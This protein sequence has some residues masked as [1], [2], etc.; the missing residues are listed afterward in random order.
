LIEKPFLRSTNAGH[1]GKQSEN[2]SASHSRFEPMRALANASVLFYG[3]A[4]TSVACRV[5]RCAYDWVVLTNNMFT[6]LPPD[7]CQNHGRARRIQ[8]VNRHYSHFLEGH[9]VN[10]SF[11]AHFAALSAILCT[12][13]KSCASL[14]THDGLSRRLEFGVLPRPA[15]NGVANTLPYFLKGLRGVP[16][17]HLH[18]TGVTFYEHGQ[19]YVPGYRLS[20]ESYRHDVAS[21]KNYSLTEL[22]KLGPSVATIDY[23][24]CASHSQSARSYEM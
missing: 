5:D 24:D 16:L 17:R 4:N 21:N 9:Y 12:Y 1:H 20:A 22:H 19:Q 7:P 15:V 8:L 3:P 2:V 13:H 6:L 10:R 23:P 11:A 18:V 14:W